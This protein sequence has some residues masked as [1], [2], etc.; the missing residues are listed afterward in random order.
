MVEITATAVKTLRELTGLPM[1]QCKKAL[2]EAQGNQD[3]AIEVLKRDVGKVRSKLAGKSTE[4][5]RIFTSVKDDGNQAVMV[6]IQC[7]SAPVA[8]GEDMTHLGEL[9]VKQLI[10]GPGAETPEQLLAQAAPDEDSKTLNELF[11]ELV[12]RI[13]E[14]IVITRVAR[15]PGP[16]AAYVHHDGKTGVLFQA[17]G[18]NATAPIL[19]D[20]AM[21]IAALNSAVVNAEDLETALV[22]AERTRLADEAK[23]TGK[24][25][26]IVEKIVNGRMKSFYVEE[27]VLVLQ[28]FVKDDS[29]T[30][31]QALAEHGLEATGFVCWVIGN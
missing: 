23:A 12:N 2:V 26:N 10:Q 8:G 9:L 13:R 5:G 28:P 3:Q 20:V 29:K 30:V 18:Q 15:V 16:V 14:K 22:E 4:E 25:D 17:K 19:R 1:M 11:D 31:S 7:Q 6:E 24:P 27:G 21:H